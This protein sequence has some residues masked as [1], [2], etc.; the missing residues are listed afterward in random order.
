MKGNSS[1]RS[2]IGK[3]PFWVSALIIVNIIFICFVA[4]NITIISSSNEKAADNLSNSLDTAIASSDPDAVTARILD[5]REKVNA[6]EKIQEHSINLSTFLALLA[7][8]VTLPT[9]IPYIISNSISKKELQA[10]FEDEFEKHLEKY[11]MSMSSIKKIDGHYARMTGYLLGVNK[12]HAWAVGWSAQALKK[13]IEIEFQEK[14]ITIK[15]EFYKNC[16]DEIRCFN[17]TRLYEELDN[18]PDEHK[19][20]FKKTVFRSFVDLYDLVAYY[21]YSSDNPGK[22]IAEMDDH[23][24]DFR[25]ILTVM[26]SYL[27]D[28][29]SYKESS[30]YSTTNIGRI[31]LKENAPRRELMD[32]NPEVLI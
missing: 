31:N 5:I 20:D 19:D 22:R 13:Y 14:G 12:N 8:L 28:D 18:T 11:H 23:I 6:I 27:L 10:M 9:I 15:P 17:E 29:C 3:L 1:S 25:N 32:L 24:E 30:F 16:I 21:L 7:I 2:S 4:Y 26:R